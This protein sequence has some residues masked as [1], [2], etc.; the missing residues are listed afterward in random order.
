MFLSRS[1]AAARRAAACLLVS[2]AALLGCDPPETPKGTVSGTVV[3]KGKP[4]TGGEVELYCEAAGVGANVP[5]DESGRFALAIPIAAA[6]YQACINPPHAHP[7]EEV[8]PARM[9]AFREVPAKAR[10]L[11]TSGLTVTVNKG[12]NDVTIELK[13]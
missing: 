8:P 5:I 4:I 11:K 10:A 7:G 12:A 6:T 3:Y 2:V 9:R 13:D 1:P